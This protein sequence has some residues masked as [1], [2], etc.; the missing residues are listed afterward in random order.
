MT[1]IVLDTNVLISAMLS[2]RG[3]EA[4]VLRLALAGGFVIV[5]STE[6]LA[7][8]EGV[9]KRPRFAFQ[10][11]VI[12]RLLSELRSSAKLVRPKITLNASPDEADNRFLECAETAK[13]LYLVTGNK[14]HFPKVW[15]ETK[16]VS[17]RELLEATMPL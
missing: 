2:P 1:S 11:L 15:K 9:L 17:A 14:R 4:L 5:V 6:L 8:Y 12:Q 7:E 3:N 13:A 10:P 16:I